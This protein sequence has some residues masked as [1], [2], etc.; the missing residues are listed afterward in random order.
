MKRKGADKEEIDAVIESLKEQVF[1]I[2]GQ[3]E[4]KASRDVIKE[5]LSNFD[6][7]SAFGEQVA[8]SPRQ[9]KDPTA[10][11]GA[12][13]ARASLAGVF[14]ALLI[15]LIAHSTGGNGKELGGVVFLLTEILALITG[16]I[17]YRTKQGK[18]GAAISL[19]LIILAILAMNAK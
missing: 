6:P 13:S 8:L 19:I 12:F 7:P 3:P 5:I 15:G 2:V 14:I 16:L 9:N 4:K 11:I 17:K 10:W 18:M 1:E